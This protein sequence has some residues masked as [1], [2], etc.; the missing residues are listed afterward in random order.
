MSNTTVILLSLSDTYPSTWA[1]SINKSSFS[2]TT[3]VPSKSNF[4]APSAFNCAIAL[5]PSNSASAAL[6]FPNTFPYLGPTVLSCGLN[7]YEVNALTSSVNST[8]LTFNSSS[9]ISL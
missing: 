5:F 3:S 4:N 1:V 7:E 6:I 8:V 9:M 2:R